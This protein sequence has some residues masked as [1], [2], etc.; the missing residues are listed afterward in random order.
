[1][2]FAQR[3]KAI[4]NK[5]IVNEVMQDDVNVLR[6]VIRQ[7]KVLLHT[8]TFILSFSIASEDKDICLFC[9]K[10]ELVR[11]KANGTPTN[12]NGS[13]ST[14]WNARRSL[15]LL[16]LS[17]N[18]PMTLSHIED[19]SDEE[20][21]I[22]E[23]AVERLCIQVG[24]QSTHS[25]EN[26]INE[27]I[28]ACVSS[29][30]SNPATPN[31]GVAC[32]SEQGSDEADVNMEDC[33]L[34]D[35]TEEVDNHG[36]VSR[37]PALNNSES[38]NLNDRQSHQ[39]NSVKELMVRTDGNLIDGGSAG[40][41]IM[42]KLVNTECTLSNRGSTSELEKSSELSIVPCEVSPVLRSPTLSVSPRAN[43]SSRKSLRTSSMLSASQKDLAEDK[44]LNTEFVHS[45]KS[46]FS[47]ALV[48]QASKNS[49]T[50]T[51]Q[52]AA[53]LHRGLQI[54]DNHRQSSAFRRSSFRFSY[55]P[56]DL[57]P[58]LPVDKVDVGIQTLPQDFD[59]PVE[60]SS[61][62]LCGNCKNKTPLLEFKE[63]NVNS[64]LQLVPVEGSSSVEKIKKQ[65]PKVW[66][67]F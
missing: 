64:G 39:K 46:S 34:G 61:V 67:L 25:E 7:L 42:E 48:N 29:N 58:L 20:M 37:E 10:D 13:Y 19:D 57:K 21:E 17:L 62:F 27:R 65:V 36:V 1:M 49:T 59:E 54:M 41:T 60:D 44:K 2:R 40:E 15:N 24:L 52:L 35:A 53:S 8:L 63:E 66:F 51:E 4:K 30:I 22:D 43:N 47:N 56:V 38:S 26:N 11:M 6:E 12:A 14:S 45:P 18:R 55:K 5:A 32:D 33:Q 3:A 50:Q 16:K 23:E 31:S 9:Q 28:S